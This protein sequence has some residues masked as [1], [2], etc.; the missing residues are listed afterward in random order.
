M[1]KMW[2]RCNTAEN[3]L[4]KPTAD[5]DYAAFVLAEDAEDVAKFNE[6]TAEW[7]RQIIEPGAYYFDVEEYSWANID[8]EVMSLLMRVDALQELQRE[9]RGIEVDKE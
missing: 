5:T 1:L 9:M 8:A 7:D 6:M 2:K 4:G 3:V